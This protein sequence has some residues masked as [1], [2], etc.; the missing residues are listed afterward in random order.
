MLPEYE[1]VYLI[2]K[3]EVLASYQYVIILKRQ[4]QYMYIIL[5]SLHLALHLPST[6]LVLFFAYIPRNSWLAPTMCF[7]Y[8]PL[9]SSL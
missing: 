7:R 4:Y 9:H 3:K 2:E 1:H 6:P 5:Y 8:P